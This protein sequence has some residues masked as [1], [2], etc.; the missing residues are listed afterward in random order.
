MEVDRKGWNQD[1]VLEQQPMLQF[2]TYVA[3]TLSILNEIE[4]TFVWF[5]AL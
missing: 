1:E 2:L 5:L 3:I 4:G